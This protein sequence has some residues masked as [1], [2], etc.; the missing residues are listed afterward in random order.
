METETC[1][2]VRVD[3][4]ENGER[5]FFYVQELFDLGEYLKAQDEWSKYDLLNQHGLRVANGW[6]QERLTEELQRDPGILFRHFIEHHG[7]DWFRDNI[8]P[9]FVKTKTQLLE[10]PNLLCLLAQPED[11]CRQ[12]DICLIVHNV[13]PGQISF[14]KKI[15]RMVSFVHW[16]LTKQTAT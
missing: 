9:R 12:C 7:H 8:R 1:H 5:R 11:Y 4:A 3:I 15:K 13:K 2:Y 14:P 6:S 10:N 16:L